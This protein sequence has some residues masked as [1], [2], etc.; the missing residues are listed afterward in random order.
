M[1]DRVKQAGE[2][3]AEAP[4]PRER[5]QGITLGGQRARADRLF[6]LGPGSITLGEGRSLSFPELVI[7]PEDRIALTGPNGSGKSTLIRHILPGISP[8][9]LYVPQEI[10][11]DES[12]GILEAVLQEEEPVRGEVFSRFSRLG[13]DPRFLFR[14]ALP[15][16]GEIRKLMIARGIFHEPALVVMDEP[17]NHLDLVSIGLLETALAGYAGALLLVSHDERFLSRLTG[18]R[19]TIRRQGQD[20]SLRVMN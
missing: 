18:K 3:L 12:R 11:P 8:P 2:T 20:S 10:G 19:W 5:K 9:V 4:S 7:T 15:S 6:F 1:K 16:P 14:S 13:S 17:T